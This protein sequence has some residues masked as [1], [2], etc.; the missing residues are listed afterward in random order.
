MDMNLIPYPKG[1]SQIEKVFWHKQLGKIF[2]SERNG[3]NFIMRSSLMCTPHQ[4][5][6]ED[7]VS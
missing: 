2:G 1:R 7:S 3:G 4:I 6:L 5:L